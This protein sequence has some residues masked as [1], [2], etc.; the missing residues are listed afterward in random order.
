MSISKFNKDN[1]Y[2]PKK[3]NENEK[4]ISNENKKDIKLNIKEKFRKRRRKSRGSNQTY[5]NYS[6]SNF[7]SRLFFHW[8]SQIFKIS[9]LK[10]EDVCNVSKEQSIKYEIE[11]IKNTF[12]KYNSGKFKNHSLLITI[13]LSNWKLLLF[14]FILDLFNVGFDYV[15]MFFYRQIISIFSESN[16]FPSR[17]KF[18][19]L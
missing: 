8:P 12:Q 5:F 13:F 9:K 1:K 17:E 7:I 10:H 14:L 2:S 16:F 4:E 19:F 18:N 11:G 6:K 3:I 15:R